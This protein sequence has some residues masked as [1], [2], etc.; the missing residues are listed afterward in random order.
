DLR[1]DCSCPDDANPCK[2]VAAV[3]FV[4]GEAFDRDP[5]LLFEL[6][7]RSRA[8]VLETL[9]AAR[10]RDAESAD[11]AGSAAGKK[12]TSRRGDAKRRDAKRR[13]VGRPGVARSEAAHSEVGRDA[14]GRSE[15]A[16]VSLGRVASADYDRLR[17][18]LPTLHFFFDAPPVSGALLRQLGAPPGWSGALPADRLGPIVRAAADAARGWALESSADTLAVPGSGEAHGNSNGTDGTSAS[19][20]RPRARRRRR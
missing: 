20:R 17:D 3:H 5:F 12:S 4:L 7:G 19:G 9:R 18:T 8:Q 1:T 14:V 10:A 13:D 6:R 2:H 16:T 11:E 15:V